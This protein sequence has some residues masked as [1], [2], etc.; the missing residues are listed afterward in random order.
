MGTNRASLR[1]RL[2]PETNGFHPDMAGRRQGEPS[3]TNRDYYLDAGYKD[4][5]QICRALIGRTPT[6]RT[7]QFMEQT[8]C[9]K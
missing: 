3:Q 4:R 6:K 5:L 8:M 2:V 9:P 1:P 7:P